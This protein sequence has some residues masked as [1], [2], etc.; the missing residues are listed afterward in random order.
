MSEPKLT[1]VETCALL[2][3]MGEAREV[4][5][6][7]LT[8]TRRLKLEKKSR[9]RLLGLKLITVRTQK[10]L[11]FLELTDAGWRRASEEI[12]ADVP[13]RAG[14]MGAAL[15]T[16]L[17]SLRQYLDRSGLAPV[18]FYTALEEVNPNPDERHSPDVE[19]MI[20][21]AYGELATAAGDWVTLASLRDSLGSVSKT[22]IDNALRQ[23]GRTPDVRLIPESNQ[24]TLS[25][26]ERAAAVHIGNEDKHLIAIGS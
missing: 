19:T 1:L 14:A 26:A 15:Y 13:P 17:A 10:R 8:N 18:E 12:G 2:T 9:E 5:N 16:Q 25:G 4:P 21:K 3:L 7:Y 24:K 22:E 6:S 23:L 20:R 11:L